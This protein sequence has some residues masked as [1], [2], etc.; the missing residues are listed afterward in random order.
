MPRFAGTLVEQEPK[1]PR[2]AGVPVAAAA[3]APVADPGLALPG[4]VNEHPYV[5]PTLIDHIMGALDYV[6]NTGAIAADRM[7]EGAS[8]LV[9]LPVELVNI[10]PMAANLFGA[11]NTPI[12]DYPIGGMEF[13]NDL[14]KGFGLVPDAPEPSDPFQTIIGRVGEEVGGSLIPELGL[15]TKAMRM[16]LPAVR[17]GSSL[18][19]MFLEQAAVDPAKYIG[20]ETGAAVAA[21]TG[22]GVANTMLDRETTGGRAADIGGALAGVGLS[23]VGGGIGGSL[24]TLFAAL[25]GNPKYA[26]EIVRQNAADT[27]I[28][29]SDQLGAQVDPANPNA[30]IDTAE[31]ADII[32]RPSQAEQV[33]PGYQASTAD[34]ASDFGWA[35]LENAR[36]KG[37]NAGRF[38]ARQDENTRAIDQRLTDI[39]PTEEPAVF[40]TALDDERNRQLVGAA[41]ATGAAQSDFDRYIQNLAPQMD[42]ETRG[43]TVR[44]GVANAE[45]A[46]R[47]VED[48]AW[49]ATR[50]AQVDPA[51]LAD[52]LDATRAGLTT[53]RQQSIAGAAQTIDIPRQLS[54][55]AGDIPAGPVDIAELNDMRSALLTQ[56]REAR[57][58]GDRNRVEA[59]GRFIEDINGYLGSDAVPA[60]VRAAT[61]SARA[62]SADVNERFN[63]PND[64]LAR[65]LSAS[66]GRPDLPDSGVAKSFIQPD[67]GQASNIDRLLAETDLSS[68][69]R[70]VREALADEIRAGIAK[71][72]GNPAR[73]E[74]YLNSN[75][76]VFERFP[77]LRDEVAGAATAGRTAA[78]ATAA[79]DTLR[80]TLGTPDGTVPGRGAV[81]DYLRFGNE[82]AETAMS[83]VVN[84]AD[85]ARAADELLAFVG[86]EPRAVEG[87]RRAFWQVMERAARSKNGAL[88]T[89]DGIDPWLTKKWRTFLDQ[90]KVQ[91]VMDRLYRDQPEQADAL[92][93][94][95]TALR[96]VQTGNK[97]GAAINPSG[98]AQQMRNGPITL[99]EA[100]AK[101]IDV[102]RGRLNPLYAVTYLAGKIAHRLVSK[103][104]EKAYQR[105][106]DEALLNPE[107]ASALLHAENPANR[108]ALARAAKGW[109]VY[110]AAGLT[111][112]LSQLDDEP[113][114]A[115]DEDPV[116][117]AVMKGAK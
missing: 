77:D 58:A 6:D 50:G 86:D 29:N 56:Q 83:N 101:F 45:R 14:T 21:G 62:V 91:A 11:H 33:I 18:T 34:R 105:L 37:D 65:T 12:T 107:V 48:I 55:P 59:L 74:A 7:R 24:K 102:Q 27:L 116:V 82:R 117:S 54:T 16:G 30:P 71:Q 93:E 99:A 114:P 72:N 20:K 44:G 84:A 57:T 76:R 28:K 98:S 22:A 49:D 5:P 26:S 8:N 67:S 106:L 2:F 13:M 89:A 1:K 68:H 104:A 64:P 70:S 23:A 88:E 25:T 110:E 36:S 97:A 4:T 39:G 47:E 60:D 3:P 51:P 78:A 80:R 95:A 103:Q 31:L 79:E 115:D 38:R 75:S 113:A 43:A 53:A 85:P 52:T 17:R 63:R 61:D 66:E 94:I 15:L 112:L 35:S 92:R 100:Q 42:A 90:P 10:A 19:K 73:I 69:G 111:E 109:Q 46:A 9:G 32:M 81:A 108:A 41:N 96:G 40:R 87:A